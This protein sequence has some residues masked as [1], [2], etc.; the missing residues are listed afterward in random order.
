MCVSDIV[1]AGAEIVDQQLSIQIAWQEL[2]CQL[3]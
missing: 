3:S 1:P 2:G